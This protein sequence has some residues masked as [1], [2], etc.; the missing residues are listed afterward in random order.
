MLSSLYIK[1]YALIENIEVKFDRGLNIITGETGAG[2]SIIIDALGLILGERAANEV[3]R[4]GANKS[5]VEG[6]FNVKDNKKI[7][8]LLIQNDLDVLED[9]IVR[10]EI[11]LKGNNRCF[12]NDS[13]V[14]LSFVKEIGDLLVDLHGQHEHQSLL[15][16]DTHCEVLDDFGMEI[17]KLEIYRTKRNELLVKSKELKELSKKEFDLRQKRDFYE[18]QIKEIDAVAPGENE[19]ESI[20]AELNILENSE[21]LIELTD[22]VYTLLYDSENSIYDALVDV[23]NQIENLNDIDKNF[24]EKLEETDSALTLINDIAE[25]VRSYKDKVDLDPDRLDEMRERQGA[26]NHL[27]KKFGGTLK[28]VLEYREKIGSEFDLAANFKDKIDS[29]QKEI[30]NLR[31]ECGDYAKEISIQRKKISKQLNSEIINSLSELGITESK[32]EVKQFH[33]GAG[34]NEEYILVDGKKYKFDSRGYDRVEFYISTNPGEDLKPLSKVASGGEISRIMLALKSSLAKNDK[35]PL[36]IFDEIDVGVSGRI[37]KKVGTALKSLAG[38]HQIIAI[39]HLPQIAGLSD[40][41]Y[42]VEKK[43]SND[44]VVSSIRKLKPEEKVNEVAKLLSGDAITE[45][46]IYAAKELMG[47]SN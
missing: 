47:L 11:S 6:V 46:N 21:R 2:K 26:L 35:L 22:N 3:V 9:L 38:H 4:K 5:I 24:T 37:A 40:S 7:I 19:D 16:V 43:K 1:D 17:S 32:F 18:H 39:T 45:S 44:R 25:Y 28:A 20:S 27:K 42:T 14:N 12:V 23:K 29:L 36:L 8:E 30:T 41:H 31:I 13:P 33:D 10:R 34:D 15:K